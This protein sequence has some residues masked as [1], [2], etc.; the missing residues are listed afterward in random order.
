MKDNGKLLQWIALGGDN[1]VLSPI[2][3]TARRPCKRGFPV[4]I[5]CQIINQSINSFMRPVPLLSNAQGSL[6]QVFECAL[7]AV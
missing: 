6:A 3:G 7:L 2:N 4:I 1:K 5:I